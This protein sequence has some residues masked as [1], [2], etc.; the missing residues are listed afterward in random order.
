MY[1]QFFTLAINRSFTNWFPTIVLPIR[2]TMDALVFDI[3][4][5][6]HTLISSSRHFSITLQLYWTIALPVFPLGFDIHLN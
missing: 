6:I 2:S 5:H 3:F 4:L 1:L